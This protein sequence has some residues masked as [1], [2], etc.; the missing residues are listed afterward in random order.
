MKGFIFKHS[1]AIDQASKRTRCCGIYRP[2]TRSNCASIGSGRIVWCFFRWAASLIIC[3]VLIPMSISLLQFNTQTQ[4]RFC[5]YHRSTGFLSVATTWEIILKLFDGIL[6]DFDLT[7]EEKTY[8][9]YHHLH[10]ADHKHAVLIWLTNVYISISNVYG[11]S[12]RTGN[13]FRTTDV[14]LKMCKRI[15]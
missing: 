8:I 6:S 15:R 2:L 13:I 1:F 14:F 3:T 11:T 7:T 5:T 10:F 12:P 4:S 9:D